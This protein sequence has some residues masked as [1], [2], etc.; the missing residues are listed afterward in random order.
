MSKEKLSER[1]MS[2]F[3]G[4]DKMT[5][6]ENRSI[7]LKRVMLEIQECSRIASSLEQEQTID[8]L[9][10]VAE[11]EIQ[12]RLDC[13]GDYRFNIGSDV[14]R[15]RDEIREYETLLSGIKQLRTTEPVKSI[16]VSVV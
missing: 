2:L 10:G 16:P 8:D 1:L 12:S 13:I 15:W 4:I 6:A 14:V 3:D 9:V 7:G 5:K 11:A